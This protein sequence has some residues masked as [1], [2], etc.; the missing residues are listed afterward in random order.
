M[1]LS[2]YILLKGRKKLF[3]F[4]KATHFGFLRLL[5]FKNWLN[6]FTYLKYLHI[7]QFQEHVKFIHPFK[8]PTHFPTIPHMN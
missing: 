3:T 7:F 6:S 1:S 4:K 8:V 2:L 5:G